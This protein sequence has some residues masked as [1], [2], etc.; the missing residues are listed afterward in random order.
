M[1]L[2]LRLAP[3]QVLARTLGRKETLTAFEQEKLDFWQRVADGYE[4]IF[5]ERTN[6]VTLDAMQSTETLCEQAL[7]RV[8]ELQ[9]I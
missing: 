2:F 1:T 9:K 3:T 8:I 5:A 7:K 4:K 6:V